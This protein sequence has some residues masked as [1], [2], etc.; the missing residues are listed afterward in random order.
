MYNKLEKSLILKVNS[1]KELNSLLK[2][3]P[4]TKDLL[5]LL[6]QNPTYVK[7]IILNVTDALSLIDRAKENTDIQ[8]D[9]LRI[10]IRDKVFFEKLVSSVDHLI[11]CYRA[12]KP[13]FGTIFY[14]VT[15]NP[16]HLANILHNSQQFV[17]LARGIDEIRPYM[18]KLLLE[19]SEWFEYVVRDFDDLKILHKGL[20]PMD[21]IDLFEFLFRNTQYFK[22][23]VNTS[24]KFFE[25]VKLTPESH[26]IYTALIANDD[27][28]L[29][30]YVMSLDAFNKAIKTL[31]NVFDDKDASIIREAIAKIPS[32]D[33]RTYYSLF[34]ST[35]VCNL[36]APKLPQDTNITESEPGMEQMLLQ[37]ME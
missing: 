8:K 28:M 3:S 19:D 24:E 22:P 10:I 25:I 34:A 15:L 20:H 5:R 35:T 21:R 23:I 1:Y 11:E 16:Q 37:L 30:R 2:N 7:S 33:T 14:N 4:D 36:N 27:D 18:M 29:K 17:K 12:H 31:P 13:Y 32:P 26:E 6:S 9:L